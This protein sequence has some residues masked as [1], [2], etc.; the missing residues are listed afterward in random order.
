VRTLGLMQRLGVARVWVALQFGLTLVLLLVGL[1]WTR[2][3]EKHVWEVVLSLLIP[4]VLAICML[5]LQAGTM[6]RLADDDGRRVT[7]VW[8][9]VTLVVWVAVGAAFWVFLDWCDNQIPLWAGYLNSKAPAGGRATWFTFEHLYNGLGRM[10][11]VLRWVVLPAKL[12]PYGVASA[13]WGWRIPWRRVLRMLWNWRWWVAVVAA[14]LV[15]VC[16]PGRFFVAEPSG[17]VSAQVWHVGLKLA[18]TYLMAVGC[19]VLLLAWVA[20]LFGRQAPRPRDEEELVRVPVA[21]R[22]PRFSRGAAV[23]IPPEDD[24]EVK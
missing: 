16:L 2:L 13:Q 21:S 19:W 12:I 5:E 9:A 17:A 8:G 4:V 15:A 14:A 1:A 3:P 18:A 6:R 10:E 11:W 20:T 22:P 23:E 24:E 7:L